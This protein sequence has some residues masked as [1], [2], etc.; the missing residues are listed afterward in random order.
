M[1]RA[2]PLA[3]ISST[4]PDGPRR[5]GRA[6]RML[7]GRREGEDGNVV[8]HRPNARQAST[9]AMEADDAA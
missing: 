1:A 6:G 2:Q 9:D 8:V 3:D 7:P 4:D 5:R